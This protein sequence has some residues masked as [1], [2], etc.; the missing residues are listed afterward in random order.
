M[1][2]SLI[3]IYAILF[4]SCYLGNT[5]NKKQEVSKNF[6][7][8]AYMQTIGTYDDLAKQ[9]FSQEE[10]CKNL[11]NANYLNARYEEAAIWYGKLFEL[12]ETTIAPDYL[13]RY[14]Q[15]LK[16]IENYEESDIWME[17]F[18]TIKATDV[19]A[20]KFSD[21]PEYL[22][23]IRK[24][25]VRYSVKNLST[26]NSDRSE[27]APSLYLNELVFSTDRDMQH[28]N[29][30][31]G[32]PY[33]NLY[34]ASVLENT[35]YG[36]VTNFSTELNA[37]TNESSTAFTKDGLRVYFTRN[38]SNNGNFN[39]DKKGVSRLKI[40]SANLKGG[41]WTDIT[42]LPFNDKTYSVAH[43]SLN[44]NETKLFFSSDMPG[45]VGASDIFY[46]DINS[47]GTFGDP[48]NLG[49]KINTEGKETFPFISE[50]GT[51]YF[52]SDGHPGLG[53]LDLFSVDLENNGIVTN[54]GR[55][56]NSKDD[57]FSL[58][59]DETS[60]SGFF[61]SN[62]YGGNGGDDIYR[63]EDTTDCL[64]TVEGTAIDKDNASSLKE[65]LIMAYDK[66]QT[67]LAEVKTQSD[68]SFVLTLPCQEEQFRLVGTLN[69]YVDATLYLPSSEININGVQLEIEQKEKVANV[70]S[71]L[72]K[73]LK[74][75]PI[76][77]DLNS[78]YVRT[79]SYAELDKVVDYMRKRPDIKIAVG[80]HTDSREGDDYNLWLSARRAKRTVE[81][82]TA[83]GIAS[84]RISGRGYGE[85][86]LINKCSNGV[87]C[88]RREHQLNR[89]SEFIVIEK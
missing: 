70:G 76:Y 64:I 72:T 9:G 38:N 46:V 22:E 18:E 30:K 33:L 27:F 5:Q 17:K 59:I 31:N 57:D 50:S 11:G 65:A 80:S 37:K 2:V 16:S 24:M 10:I 82:I 15:S 63:F 42:E 32:K 13:Y 41:L 52:S 12:K 35:G 29:K 51:L 47:D 36:N 85:T 71:D 55:P 26:I 21:N 1:K 89:R 23:K 60:Q 84:N 4:L 58:I 66:N 87:R 14:A 69:D 40:Y 77:F 68:G 20:V 78:S 48:K 79:D 25:S 81:Y 8:Y 86:Q 54:M 43:P 6:E 74:L 88:S 3:H 19:R 62:R 53:G 75:E 83:K 61:A 45:T 28:I 7:S 34:S 44:A 49:P 39:R 73:V 56:L 67:K